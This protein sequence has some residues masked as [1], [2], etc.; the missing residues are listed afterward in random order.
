MR[1]SN[2]LGFLIATMLAP[3]TAYA[4]DLGPAT[5][6]PIDAVLP[7]SWTGF[8]AG[9]NAGYG[10]GGNDRAG[11]H[12]DNVFLGD[13]G[14]LENSGFLGGVQAGYN[15]QTGSFVFGLEADFQGSA[16]EDTASRTA[17][18]ITARARS[19]IEWFGTVRPRIGY[20][21]DRTLVYATG[22]LAYGDVDYNGWA[23][24]VK[25]LSDNST[26][27]GWVAGAGV[28]Q[29]ITDHFSVKLEYQFV[30]F[31]SYNITGL[32]G[33]LSTK[34]TP[35]FHSVRVGLNYRF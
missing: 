26:R 3:A 25:V 35:E 1:T 9:V 21:F 17:L 34:A 27:I 29:A 14:T 12:L 4:A 33:R 20:A 22:G 19:N 5:P 18:G 7:F 13:V 32:G 31:D 6:E 11:V 28:E 16:I 10:F 23:D 24:G 30:D 15:Y 8:Y 2:L